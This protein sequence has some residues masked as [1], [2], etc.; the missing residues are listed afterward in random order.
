MVTVTVDRSS[1]LG[2]ERNLKHYDNCHLSPKLA[3]S[4]HVALDTG[5]SRTVLKRI[6]LSSEDQLCV[7]PEDHNKTDKFWSQGFI[8][9]RNAKNFWSVWKTWDCHCPK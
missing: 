9:F 6:L 5:I 7:I 2:Y 4:T 8:C 1:V 3:L